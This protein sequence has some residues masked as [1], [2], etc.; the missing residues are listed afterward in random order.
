MPCW[1]RRWRAEQCCR[2]PNALSAKSGR[3]YSLHYWG[4]RVVLRIDTPALAGLPWEA[5]YDAAV[6]GYVCRRDQLIRHVPVASVAAPLTVRP[7]LRILG[8]YRPVSTGQFR[9][10]PGRK[11]DEP[12]LRL[13][14]LIG[15]Q[16]EPPVPLGLQDLSSPP[17]KTAGLLRI[18]QGPALRSPR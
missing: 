11:D 10:V 18:L 17:R 3:C 4:L 9:E 8:A 16:V 15:Q 13:R 12:L 7:P 2:R 6:G 1:R 14:H 5:M